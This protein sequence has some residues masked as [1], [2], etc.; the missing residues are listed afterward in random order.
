MILISLAG[1][2]WT[3]WPLPRK[4]ASLTVTGDLLTV[5]GSSEKLEG[6]T[7]RLEYP[8]QLRMGEIGQA[9]MVLEPDPPGVKRAAGVNV[10]AEAWLDLPGAVIVPGDVSRTAVLAG[11]TNRFDWLI[12]PGVD[13]EMQGRA[14]LYF[15]LIP[16]DGSAAERKPISAQ[17]IN[18]QALSLAGLGV[19]AVRWMGAGGA[20]VGLAGLGWGRLWGKGRAHR[21]KAKRI[22]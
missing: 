10:E 13:Q 3:V 4:S 22:K 12:S 2:I 5:A 8:A 18:V 11:R 7:V 17:A 6:R 1:V 9:E 19:E 16:S 21:L 20:L 15:N 14:W